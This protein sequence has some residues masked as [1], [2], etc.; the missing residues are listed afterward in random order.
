[1]RVFITGVGGF[2]G[3]ELARYLHSKGV[4]VR[5][6]S[7][8]VAKLGSIVESL[9]QVYEFGL[10]SEIDAAWFEGCDAVV[11]CAYDGRSGKGKVNVEGTMRIYAA[12]ASA[13]VPYQLF[14]GSHSARPDAVS[15][16]GRH[17]YEIEK[18]F[19]EKGQ[20]VIRPGLVVGN[21]G[22]YAENKRYI[23][24]A[25]FLVLP[26]GKT[27]PI[28]Y[29]AAGDLLCCVNVIIERCMRGA[30]NIFCRQP[31]SLLDFSL[32]I[33]KSESRRKVVLTVPFVPL[34]SMARYLSRRIICLSDYFLRMEAARLNMQDPVH[35]SD[36]GLFMEF[37]LL[38]DD[39]VKSASGGM[40]RDNRS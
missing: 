11:H 40:L 13:G 7:H 31:A 38:L 26:G 2:I 35:Q 25:P 18:L 36:I 3:G 19:I 1:M 14:I 29:V 10:D 30:Y 24:R 9:E 23:L 22:L 17:K 15:E 28:Y 33:L 37:P 32:A 12:A 4:I 20:A 27:V 6:S 8:D 16:Y 21:G 5:G 34:L 39:A